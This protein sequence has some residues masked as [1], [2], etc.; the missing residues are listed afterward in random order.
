MGHKIDTCVFGTSSCVQ[1]LKII[2]VEVVKKRERER[3]EKRVSIEKDQRT[4]N[5]LICNNI[6]ANHSY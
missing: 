3:E 5:L 2:N 6:I 4:Q 1:T